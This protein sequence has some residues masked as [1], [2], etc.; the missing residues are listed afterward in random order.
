LPRQRQPDHD[1]ERRGALLWQPLRR[2]SDACCGLEPLRQRKGSSPSTWAGLRGRFWRRRADPFGRGHVVFRQ[3]LRRHATCPTGGGVPVLH[4]NETQR[5]LRGAPRA[6]SIVP[7]ILHTTA[8]TVVSA[9][10]S[11]GMA[12]VSPVSTAGQRDVR[13]RSRVS[14]TAFG[15]PPGCECHVMPCGVAQR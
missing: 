7:P 1:E 6:I 15:T 9:A 14:H 11:G 4:D 2:R 10:A 5:P 13:S 12:A 3:Q 8:R